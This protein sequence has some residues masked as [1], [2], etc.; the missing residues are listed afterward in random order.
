MEINIDVETVAGFF[1]REF[2]GIPV[3]GDEIQYHELS[4]RILDMDGNRINKLMIEMRL[5]S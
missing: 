2:G 5:D 3:P 1:L 4:I